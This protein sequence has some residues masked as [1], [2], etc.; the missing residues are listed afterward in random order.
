MSR[1]L[2]ALAWLVEMGADEA[3]LDQPVDHCVPAT[4]RVA[5]PGVATAETRGVAGTQ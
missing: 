3:I 1:D 5:A 2:D 4:P